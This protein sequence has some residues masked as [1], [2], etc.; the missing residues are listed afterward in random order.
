VLD[1][2]RAKPFVIDA[3]EQTKEQTCSIGWAAFPWF[4]D[5]VRSIS[6]EGVIKFADRGLYRAKK[7]GKNQAIGMIP[8]GEGASAV[9]TTESLSDALFESESAVPDLREN[10]EFSNPSARV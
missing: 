3:S 10:L 8:S 7:A 9:S 4:E 5:D 6:F 2:F 1:A